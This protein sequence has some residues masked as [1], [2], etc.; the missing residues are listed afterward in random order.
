MI[1]IRMWLKDRHRPQHHFHLPTG[2]RRWSIQQ[3]RPCKE[4]W[5]VKS[6]VLFWFCVFFHSLTGDFKVKTFPK[7][8]EPPQLV[9]PEKRR[10]KA[11]SCNGTSVIMCPYP[12]IS[13]YHSQ[14][15][16][17][18]YTLATLQKS[19]PVQQIISNTTMRKRKEN[20]GKYLVSL[21]E[22]MQG[23]NIQPDVLWRCW[24][25]WRSWGEI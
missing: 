20:T 12:P 7:L 19:A 21:N 24:D 22:G 6:A 15:S 13:G 8:P 1:F 5:R 2:C 25:Q 11:H 23:C 10:A 14:V 3:R 17:A 9:P 4:C 16:K 18:K